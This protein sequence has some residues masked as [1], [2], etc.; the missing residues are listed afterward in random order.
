MKYIV[1]E[2]EKMVSKVEAKVLSQLKSIDNNIQ[3]IHYEHGHYKEIESTLREYDRS[4]NF[5]NKK[6]PLIAL[7][8]DIRERV[9]DGILSEVNLSIVICFHTK[10]DYKS[11]DRYKTIFK[12]I[13]EPIY[14][15]LM[16]EIA[17]NHYFVGYGIP[18]HDKINRPY[19]GSDAS[20]NDSNIF[21]D[22]L[23][24]IEISNLRLKFLPNNC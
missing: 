4:R 11:A 19:W 21:G 23:D 10:A 22:Y 16:E 15:A 5:F 17:N 1:D 12:P 13:L 9:R 8:E 3:Q 6:Y 24:A 2:F 20:N 18:M 7:F 14:N